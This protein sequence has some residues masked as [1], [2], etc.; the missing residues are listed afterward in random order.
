MT[1]TVRKG[2]GRP[3]ATEKSNRHAQ[4][5]PL[6]PKAGVVEDA[7]E[8]LLTHRKALQK[9]ERFYGEASVSELKDR[10][11]ELH[12][13][14]LPRTRGKL[15]DAI[16][17][18]EQAERKIDAQMS[19]E[20]KTADAV[21]AAFGPAH[22]ETQIRAAQARALAKRLAEDA[23]EQQP[24]CGGMAPEPAGEVEKR[25]DTKSGR[26]AEAFAA[27]ALRLGWKV[28]AVLHSGDQA[29]VIAV[30]DG[31]EIRIEWTEGL[32]QY[33]GTTYTHP[34]R[35]AVKLRN[36]SAAKAQMLVPP[37]QAAAKAATV[38]AHKSVR[39]S[40]AAD[41][42][43]RARP[44]K[45]L[46]FS[47]ASLDQEVLDVLYGKRVT[48]I[49]RISGKDEEDRVPDLG[50]VI[51][52]PRTGERRTRKQFHPP[53]IGESRSGRVLHFVGVDGFHS[54]LVSAIVR[55]R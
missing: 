52:D 54:V 34:G 46:P 48:W 50:E 36:A 44:A 10:A 31:E 11:R 51:T 39:A 14:P 16:Y 7:R 30:R 15:L 25:L 19:Q 35:T 27:E 23:A 47:E 45:P 3:A 37:A 8:V 21:D 26:K 42:S 20:S 13:K 1:T 38:S 22:Q 18:A 4:R 24:T 6:P 40:A 5:T 55:V 43:G 29:T 12:V 28:D 17:L 9:A 49:N 41:G 32:F 2:S 33:D 53:R